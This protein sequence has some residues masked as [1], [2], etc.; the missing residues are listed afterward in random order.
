VDGAFV[1][2]HPD[3]P[4]DVVL[5]RLWQSGGLLPVVSRSEVRRVQGVITPSSLL[6]KYAPRETAPAAD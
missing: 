3:H 1:H 6:G 2:A 4:I 5:E